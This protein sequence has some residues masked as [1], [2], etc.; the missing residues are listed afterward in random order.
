MRYFWDAAVALDPG[1][2]LGWL[3]GQ[4]RV[5]MRNS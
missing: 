3:L 2:Q 1:A 5:S 4:S